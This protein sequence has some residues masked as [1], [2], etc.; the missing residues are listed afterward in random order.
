M[1]DAVI[2]I[3]EVN[4][5]GQLAAVVLSH[6]QVKILDSV[7]DQALAEVKAMCLFAM[8]IANGDRPGPYTD[9]R[10]TQFAGRMR[11]QRAIRNALQGL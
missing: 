8:E 7:P 2:R 4:Y 5:N 1:I 3:Q 9:E 10:A 11:A 6:D